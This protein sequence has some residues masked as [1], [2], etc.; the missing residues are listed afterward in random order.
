MQTKFIKIF[1]I[2]LVSVLSIEAF[3]QVCTECD[4]NG[5]QPIC[6]N[7]YNFPLGLNGEGPNPNEING[8]NSCLGG[9]Q[10]GMWFSFTVQNSGNLCFTITPTN[11]SDDYDW[12]VYNLSLGGNW[13]CADIYSNPSLEVSC[14]WSP[15]PGPTGANGNSGMQNQPCIPV[16]A[17]DNMML[18]V[19]NFT[20]GGSGFTVGIDPNTT[21][22]IFDNTPPSLASL[23]DTSGNTSA[24]QIVCGT[25]QLELTFS[26]NIDCSTFSPADL[27]LT[28]PGGPY[29]ISSVT[30]AA[31]LS[32]FSFDKTFIVTISPGLGPVGAFD[33]ILSGAVSDQCGNQNIFNSNIPITVIPYTLTMS[34]TD[35][36]C[37]T[38]NGSA[39]VVPD[40]GA[41]PFNYLWDDPSAQTSPSATGLTPGTY[42]VTVTDNAGCITIDNVVV[43][44]Q[45]GNMPN[46]SVTASSNS[47][48]LQSNDGSATVTGN[49]GNTPYTYAWPASTGLG[50]TPNGT[51][52][53]PGNYDVTVTEATGCGDVVQVVIGNNGQAPTLAISS[54][55]NVS[56]ASINDG[57]ATLNAT[58][59]GQGPFV[60]NWP[61]SL[62]I[63]NVN[64]ATGLSAGSYMVT[65]ADN[66]GCIDSIS[67][68]IGN[69]NQ[70]PVIAVS[71][72]SNVSCS[73]VSNGSATLNSTPAA[74]GPF[75]Y[76]WPTALGLGNVNTANNLGTGSYMVTVTD[77]AGCIDSLSVPI[78]NDNLLPVIAITSSSNVS[79]SNV[80][81]GSATVNATPAGQGPFNY[82]WPPALGLGNVPTANNLGIGNY[83][84]TVT[85]NIGCIDSLSIAVGDDN[86]IPIIADIVTNASCAQS[87][88]G[89]ITVSSSGGGSVY[90]Y[91]W[92]ASMGVGNVTT[93][94]NLNPGNYSVTSTDNIGCEGTLT[95]S[96]GNDNNYP[97]GNIVNQTDATCSNTIDGTAEVGANNGS[98]TYTYVWDNGSTGAIVNGLAP[99]TYFVT[100]ND[101]K[102]CKDTI[103]VT[104]GAPVPPAVSVSSDTMICIGGTATL[105]AN[106]NGGNAPYTFEWIGI[107]LGQS[108]NVSP[109]IPT[110]YEATVRDANNC[111]GDTTSITVSQFP[112]ISASIPDPG[113]VCQGDSIQ[114]F[115][116]ANGGN[117]VFQYSWS[118]GDNGNPVWIKPPDNTTMYVTI[119]NVGCETPGEVDSVDVF[120]ASYPPVQFYSDRS[121]GCPPLSLNFISTDIEPLFKY[122]WDFGDGTEIFSLDD[123]IQ[124]VYY[125][126]GYFDVSLSVTSDSGC[127]SEFEFVTMN[128]L[129]LAVSRQPSLFETTSLT[130]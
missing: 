1:V 12:A 127:V 43:G 53:A 31:C 97:I 44:Q 62:G 89:S 47:N 2:L 73:T 88:D 100:I 17:G 102:N 30:S 69:N 50:N 64:N 36:V 77:N 78:G 40:S 70:V 121:M 5:A 4:C 90:T 57:D 45:L 98:G 81:N 106:A 67:V 99:G 35:A 11:L 79:C 46:P 92:Q 68:T 130:S 26:E 18:Y 91:T 119:T 63:G 38:P 105:S 83:M 86:D 58:P 19:S 3:S 103:S 107:G 41:A 95:I 120:I 21:A 32:G 111:P 128:T 59:A 61:A 9:E 96:I 109:T 14:N 29:T 74:Q 117:G 94:N 93:V 33:L 125:E 51:G 13:T 23:T 104:I 28:G 37:I 116:N 82:A 80:S 85:D 66:L 123:T 71:A 72:S 34:S 48:C 55:N 39:T 114:L 101:S 56:C 126:S 8:A 27:T 110:T 84:I 42:E 7:S 129:V 22:N 16:T 24:N 118:N 115:A 113:P 54:L 76:A 25:T 124:H 75:I 65:V 20:G 108:V 112:G 6:N 52:L 15:A 122:E 87:G 60:Y 10:N 49:A